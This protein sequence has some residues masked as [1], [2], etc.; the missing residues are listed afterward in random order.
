[1]KFDRRSILKF[2]SGLVPAAIASKVI[3]KTPTPPQEPVTDREYENTWVSPNTGMA[4]VVGIDGNFT[5]EMWF[6][7]TAGSDL[8]KKLPRGPAGS[9][10]SPGT[11]DGV[12]WTYFSIVSRKFCGVVHETAY[13]DGVI[14][15]ALH[16]TISETLKAGY[17]VIRNPTEEYPEYL[18]RIG[19]FRVL[20]ESPSNPDV[21]GIKSM[22]SC[23]N[24]PI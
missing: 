6:V 1:M 9:G 18:R 19:E 10:W 20:T 12:W 2:L 13:V 17:K 7:P 3:A 15:H 23:L 14:N 5:V 16:D 21:L 22:W 8:H 24:G 4:E 11:D